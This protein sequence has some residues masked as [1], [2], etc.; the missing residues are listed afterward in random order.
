MVVQIE[1][2]LLQ[3]AMPTTRSLTPDRLPQVEGRV[4]VVTAA[5][6][7]FFTSVMAEAFRMA[8]QGT[9]VL[10]VQFLKG[11]VNQGV[12]RPMNFCRTLDWFRCDL[13][14][15]LTERGCSPEAKAAV[16]HLWQHTQQRVAEGRDALV[17][18]DELSLAIHWHL[19]PEREV[20]GLLQHRLS[21]V[22]VIL[23][24]PH[25]PQSLLALADQITELRRPH[26]G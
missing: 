4:Q 16:Q 15:C 14:S 9:A 13:P 25:M 11:G 23:T 6:R 21:H 26:Q 5:H 3:R 8:G 22:D 1:S 20:L 18:L 19:I 17:V 7:S 24:G 2:S 12:D 10:V